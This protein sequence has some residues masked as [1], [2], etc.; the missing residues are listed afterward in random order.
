VPDRSG[1]RSA[2]RSGD[3]PLRGAAPASGPGRDPHDATIVERP[4]TPPPDLETTPVPPA[5]S[6]AEDSD[7]GADVT[8]FIGRPVAPTV[9]TVAW[10]VSASGPDR[11]RDYRLDDTGTTVGTAPESALRL[12]GDPYV[13]THHA[14][15]VVEG[16]VWMLRDLESTNGTCRNGDRITETPLEDDDRVRFGLSD[17]VFKVA[18]L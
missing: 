4:R 14:V 5:L 17:F 11:G 9:Q 8:R 16:G 12:T 2:G 15:L 18:R 1:S 3:R 7:A 10:L 13:S 6:G